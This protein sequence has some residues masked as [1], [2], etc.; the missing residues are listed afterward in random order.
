MSA[1]TLPIRLRPYEAE[2]LPSYLCRLATVNGWSTMAEFLLVMGIKKTKI[3][4]DVSLDR[5]VQLTHLPHSEFL[6]RMEEIPRSMPAR[7][8][9]QHSP[10]FVLFASAPHRTCVMSSTLRQRYFV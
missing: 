4:P 2:S 7:M 5:L 10:D 3:D 9:Y 6:P 8:F 1:M